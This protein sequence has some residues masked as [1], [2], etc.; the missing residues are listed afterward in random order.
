MVASDSYCVSIWHAICMTQ[1][2]QLAAVIAR[3]RGAKHWISKE[4]TDESRAQVKAML[5]HMLTEETEKL[6]RRSVADLI[7][8]I[9]KIA[10]PHG[11]WDELLQ[12]LFQCSQSE[13]PGHREVSFVMPKQDSLGHS[14]LHTYICPA[15]GACGCNRICIVYFSTLM[16]ARTHTRTNTHTDTH[17]RI[18]AHEHTFH[19]RTHTHTSTHTHT[20]TRTHT[21]THT[22]THIHAHTHTHTHTNTH[23]RT[24]GARGLHVADRLHRQPAAPAFPPAHLHLRQRALGPGTTRACGSSQGRGNCS[25]VAGKRYRDSNVC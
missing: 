7:S 4:L 8:A 3:R 5:L 20:D 10:V 17:T 2:R 23:T 15:N 22:H 12:Y 25:A 16:H 21:D 1:V 13:D 14:Y 9:A 11:Q 18:Y 19:T 24:G 6:V